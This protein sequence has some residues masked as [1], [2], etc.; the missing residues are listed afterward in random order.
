MYQ[1]GRDHDNQKVEEPI[2]ASRHSIRLAASLDRIDLSWVQPREWEPRS[3]KRSYVG[4]E[5]YGRSLGC[6]LG[7]WNKTR[8]D[9]DHGEH[10]ASSTPEE[11]LASTNTLNDEP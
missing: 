11:E 9:K 2:C 7:F 10:L 3:T 4:E 8:K 6:G 1:D 5:T